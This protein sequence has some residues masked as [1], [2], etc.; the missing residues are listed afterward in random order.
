M[1]IH[2]NFESLVEPYLAGGL[3]PAEREAFDGHVAD[4]PACATELADAQE[5]DAFMSDSLD[6]FRPPGELEERLISA[7]RAEGMGTVKQKRTRLR[8]DSMGTVKKEGSRF[9]VRFRAPAWLKVAAMFMVCIGVGMFATRGGRGES[10][11]GGLTVSGHPQSDGQP[12]A[13]KN[14]VIGSDKGEGKYFYAETGGDRRELAFS[15]ALPGTSAAFRDFQ[16][17]QGIEAY[18]QNLQGLP[19]LMLNERPAEIMEVL[20]V[21]N[22]KRPTSPRVETTAS[23]QDRKII[24]NS[25][26]DYEVDSYDDAYKT[27]QDIVTKEGGFIASSSRQKLA[28]GKIRGYIVVRVPSGKFSLTIQAM[29]GLGE[30]KNQAVTSQDVTKQYV[31]LAS[32]LKSKKTL[33]TR[34]LKMIED[35]K[36]ELKDLISIEKELG[37][38]RAEVETMQGQINYYNNLISLSTL[39]LNLSEKNIAKPFEYVQTLQSTISVT[40]SDADAAYRKAHDIVREH[41]GRIRDANM[42]RFREDQAAGLIRISI[43]AGKFPAVREALRQLGDVTTDTVERT[44]KASGGSRVPAP[45]APVRREEARIAF[46]LG[47]AEVVETVQG[48]LSVEASSVQNAYEAARKAVEDAGGEITG[49]GM[50]EHTNGATG[51]LYLRVDAAKFQTLIDSLKA[52]GD[53]KRSTITRKEGNDGNKVR[54]EKGV[55][56]MTISTPKKLVRSDEGVGAMLRDTISGSLIGLLWSLEMMFVGAAYLGP[57]LILVALCIFLYRRR[58]NRKTAKS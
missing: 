57:W 51:T 45:D 39:T 53:V 31:D 12:G 43:E 15:S 32:R 58:L 38:V 29:A 37:K 42:K 55:I 48:T 4:C 22:R 1:N 27:I 13:F 2:K 56:S 34:L 18:R 46:S 23:Y 30:L 24:K 35:G 41:G 19:D 52:L 36:G 28:N 5:F 44:Q 25:T 49:G 9:Q 47:T 54:R 11:K 6:P 10:L 50:T 26:L 20:P 7:L 8:A 17:A 3:D 14:G 16:K 33:E 40:V 21:K